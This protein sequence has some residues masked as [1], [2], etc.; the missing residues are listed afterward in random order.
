MAP[1]HRLCQDP[2]TRSDHHAGPFV[3]RVV[4]HLVSQ[5]IQK[6]PRVG[7][8]KLTF[9]LL[10]FLQ[11]GKEED[12]EPALGHTHPGKPTRTREKWELVKNS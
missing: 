5:A 4:A 1:W 3:S 12:A 6:L 10:C 7:R 8:S 2:S 9:C 11:E